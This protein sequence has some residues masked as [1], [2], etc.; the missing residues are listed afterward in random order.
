MEK[1]Y[2]VTGAESL[3]TLNAELAKYGGHVSS[4]TMVR[5]DSA[6]AYAVIV[7]EYKASSRPNRSS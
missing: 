4:V 7:V 1:V 2:W 6:G 3:K 5:D